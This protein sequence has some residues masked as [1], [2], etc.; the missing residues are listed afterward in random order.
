[1]QCICLPY[2][3][4]RCVCYSDLQLSYSHRSTA[5]LYPN[6]RR[7]R[8]SVCLYEVTVFKKY[9][10][11]TLVLDKCG[12]RHS[13]D[14]I[15]TRY[16]MD[17]TGVR[18]PVGARLSVPVHTGTEGHPA[19]CT[20]GTTGSLSREEKGRGVAM[21]TDPPPPTSNEVKERAELYLH[22]PYGELY[23]L[24]RHYIIISYCTCHYPQV[25]LLA[26]H[27]QVIS[28]KLCHHYLISR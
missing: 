12:G 9:K 19:S 2:L 3:L 10:Q 17:G 6:Y 7:A 22:S 5:L 25:F 4:T 18:T 11:F 15:A 16:E 13:V 23:L 8:L 27:T 20:R 26:S 14:G 21:T 24:L 1:M 28:F